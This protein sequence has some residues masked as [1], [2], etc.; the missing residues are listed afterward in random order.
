M[1]PSKRKTET[2]TKKWRETILRAVRAI[3]RVVQFIVRAVHAIVRVVHS[4]TI[5]TTTYDGKPSADIFLFAFRF[6]A[7]DAAE[8][9]EQAQNPNA[10]KKIEGNYT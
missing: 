8:A 4:M 2:Q 7:C 6:C 9:A 1:P 5:H 3:I 10:N